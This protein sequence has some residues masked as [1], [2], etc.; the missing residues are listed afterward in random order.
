MPSIVS[1]HLYTFMAAALVGMLL[2]SAFSSYVLAIRRVS[3]KEWLKNLLDRV[4]ARSLELVSLTKT[5]QNPCTAR[6][7]VTMPSSLGNQEYW[8]RLGNDVSKSW[9][10]GGLGKAHS[11]AGES[12]VF[13]PAKLSASGYYAGGEG[14]AVLQCRLNGSLIQLSLDSTTGGS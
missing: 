12:R 9:V 3:E 2:V 1:S 11:F 10:E 6:V 5:S 4:A 13:L 14:M 8:M 7:V